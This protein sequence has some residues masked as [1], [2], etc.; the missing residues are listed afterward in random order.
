MNFS[1][2]LSSTAQED[3]DENDVK[4]KQQEINENIQS[5]YL[6]TGV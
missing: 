4:G 5:L 2:P 1:A 3:D 6:I